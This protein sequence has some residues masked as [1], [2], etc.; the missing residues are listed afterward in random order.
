MWADQENEQEVPRSLLVL[1]QPEGQEGQEGDV[2]DVVVIRE[3]QRIDPGEIERFIR[4]ELEGREHSV[5]LS[6]VHFEGQTGGVE[7]EISIW[8][9]FEEIRSQP[10][11]EKNGSGARASCDRVVGLLIERGWEAGQPEFEL[12]KPEVPAVPRTE[13]SDGAI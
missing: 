5:R 12:A 4:E 7:G 3:A 11:V 10:R 1:Q 13:G 2:D 9:S 8:F 6:D